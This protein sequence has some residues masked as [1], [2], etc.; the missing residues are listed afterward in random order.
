MTFLS[1][2]KK[3]NKSATAGD[4]PIKDAV[5]TAPRLLH[6]IPLGLQHVLVAYSGM[7]TT[8]LLIGVGVGLSTE[9]IAV[10]VSA[11][12][13]VCGIATVLQTL[14]L[15]NIGV[16]LPIVMGSTF[17]AI[18]P[19]IVIGNDA[20]LPAVFGAT[21]V[22]GALTWLVAPWFSKLMRFFPPIVTGTIIAIIGFSILPSTANLIA[23]PDPA[24]AD[25]GSAT[26]LLLALF[27]IVLVIGLER[28]APPA[29]GRF[30]IL[31]AL[32]VGTLVAIPLGLTDF[33]GV[34][35][36]DLVGFVRPFEFGLPTFPIAAIIPMLIVQLV[37]MVESV[38]DTLAIGQIVNRKIGPNEVARALRAD[39]AGTVL[40]GVFGSPS[41]VTFGNNVGLVTITKVMSRFVVATAGI[42][43]III[44]LLPKL[45]TFVASLPGPVLGG[46][47]VVMLGT[48]GAIGIKII[49]QADLTDGR[50]LLIVAV[51]FGFG[52]LPVG[53]P[54]L[55]QHLPGA[56]NIVLTSGIAAGGIAAFLLNLLL[57]VRRG[58]DVN[59]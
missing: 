13:L 14:G 27:T 39:G 46:V 48:V 40:A 19:A 41:I 24:A 47:G 30:A 51:S 1:F 4:I 42:F 12:V 56:L 52:L 20:G 44:S 33:S 10:L 57:N 16:R 34:K 55:Y 29:V 6:M 3:R 22:A 53:A 5:D 49:G 26:G 45:G 11:N 50:N 59:G 28:F 54:Q 38:G 32:G 8:S 23:G 31:I 25:Y 37:N 35:D 36:A 58:R 43:L 7:I 2:R 9:Q 17:T 15:F 18:S 21:L